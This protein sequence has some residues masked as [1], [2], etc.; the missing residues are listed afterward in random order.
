MMSGC[1]QVACLMEVVLNMAEI[2][3]STD[4]TAGPGETGVFGQKFISTGWAVWIKSQLMCST[5]R[6][7][8]K[9]PNTLLG[10][11]PIGNDERSIPMKNIASVST[12]TAFRIG[13]FILGIILFIIAMA[14]FGQGMPLV[15][16][17]LILLVL[18]IS[19]ILSAFS[20][21]LVVRDPS[22]SAT[23]IP[24]SPIDKAK[25]VKFK[26]E[27]EQRVFADQAQ[28]HHDEAQ[29]LRMQQ[30][31]LQQLSLQNQ[32]GQQQFIDQQRLNAQQQLDQGQTPQDQH[33]GDSSQQPW[34]NS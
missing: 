18:S 31:Q 8:F 14:L 16:L 34:G 2:E 32:M 6:F 21:E 27:L 9:R 26:S 33:Q 22:G 29:Q 19:T 5:T 15:L 17:A 7:V 1:K 10:M 13:K 11:I 3:N 30:L 4:F 12:N 24:V 28:V 25:L 23:E 20:A